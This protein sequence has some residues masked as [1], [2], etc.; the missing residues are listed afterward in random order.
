VNEL[1]NEIYQLPPRSPDT[2]KFIATGRRCASGILL[3]MEEQ[4]VD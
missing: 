3:R 2:H 4:H 1:E